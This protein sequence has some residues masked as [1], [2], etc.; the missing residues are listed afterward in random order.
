MKAVLLDIWVQIAYKGRFAVGLISHRSD[1]QN[2]IVGKINVVDIEGVAVGS[3][4]AAVCS[5]SKVHDARLIDIA[6]S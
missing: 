3:F 2:T 5:E 4:D 6:L 1:T